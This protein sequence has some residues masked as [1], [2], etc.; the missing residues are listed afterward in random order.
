[1]K[2]GE[3]LGRQTSRLK[4]QRRPIPLQGVLLQGEEDPSQC[5]QGWRAIS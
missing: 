2:D 1:V 4:E 3:P 5:V